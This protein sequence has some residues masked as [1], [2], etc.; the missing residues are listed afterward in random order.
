MNKIV[1]RPFNSIIN[2]AALT[3]LSCLLVDPLVGPF[4]WLHYQKV[5]LKKS[6]KKQIDIGIEPEKLILLH[7][8]AKEARIKLKWTGP[9]EFEYNHQLYDVVKT[10]KIG[11]MIYYWCWNDQAE[12]KLDQQIEALA[13]RALGKQ[14]KSIIDL[15]RL[16]TSTRSLIYTIFIPGNL[17]RPGLLG[18]QESLF[19]LLYPSINLSPPTPPPRLLG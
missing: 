3:I 18:H 2:I 15:T 10:I 5:L 8:S 19:Y 6:V 13:A 17:P 11:Q 7:F 12:T 14:T 4:S 16:N 1:G 9:Q